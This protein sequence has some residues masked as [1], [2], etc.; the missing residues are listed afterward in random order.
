LSAQAERHEIRQ[1]QPERHLQQDPRDDEDD[2]DDDR[3]RSPT[4]REQR[5]GDLP[6]QQRSE[7][8]SE[9]AEDQSRDPY[10]PLRC[11]H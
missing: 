2:G 6:Q 10:A 9:R 11:P 7:E 4:V 8:G 3:S 5:V 1:P